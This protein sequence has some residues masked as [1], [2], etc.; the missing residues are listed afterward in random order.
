MNISALTP[1]ELKIKYW[2]KY[3][4]TLG[5]ID[6]EKAVVGEDNVS[7]DG[8]KPV[9]HWDVSSAYLL[10]NSI[11]VKFL[12]RYK[13]RKVMDEK[14]FYKTPYCMNALYRLNK[15]GNYFGIIDPSRL[16]EQGNYFLRLYHSILKGS[17]KKEYIIFSNIVVYHSSE[18]YPCVVRLKDGFWG[19]RDGH[20]RLAAHYCLKKRWAWAHIV[21]EKDKIIWS[22]K[23]I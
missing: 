8:Y 3:L 7:T 14:E 17:Y 22:Y 21:L 1:W 2:W 5:L 15:I 9:N 11:Y 4:S 20:H 16:I 6:L 12:R 23:G 19:I 10:K 18:K 13:N